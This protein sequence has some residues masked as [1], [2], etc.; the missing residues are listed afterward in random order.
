MTHPIYAAIDA[1]IAEHGWPDDADSIF[2]RDNYG[3]S[4]HCSVTLNNVTPGSAPMRPTLAEAATY[5]IAERD[6]RRALAND[7]AAAAKLRKL[8]EEHGISPELVK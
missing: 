3:K 5:A 7:L 1:A 6:A 2:L 8:A 4:L